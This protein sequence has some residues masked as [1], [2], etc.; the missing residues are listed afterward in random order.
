[1]FAPDWYRDAR[2]ET[3][4]AGADARRR[5]IL[6][7]A[8]LAET[9][10]FEWVR[11]ALLPERP[12]R[13]FEFF[14]TNDRRGVR[15]RWKEVP[16]DLH[17]AGLIPNKPDF[18]DAHRVEWNEFVDQCDRIIHTKLADGNGA[19]VAPGIDANRPGWALDTVVE[20][21]RRLHDA[22]DSPLPEW[23]LSL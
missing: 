3:Q 23:L 16:K 7:A 15:G 6:F 14:P 9:Y 4:R 19:V 11:D 12:S 5:E 8:C 20:R 13:M 17:D 2:K 21:I 18:R 1:M 22:A 10:L